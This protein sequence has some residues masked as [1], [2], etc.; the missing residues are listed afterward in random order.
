[1]NHYPTLTGIGIFICGLVVLK[2]AHFILAFDLTE[3]TFTDFVLIIFSVLFCVIGIF[4][5]LTGTIIFTLGTLG[6]FQ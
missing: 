3:Y 1:M 2:I 4:A 5:L 6:A